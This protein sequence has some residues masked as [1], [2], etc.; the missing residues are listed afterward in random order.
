MMRI[1][2]FAVNRTQQRYFLQLQ[3]ALECPA[4]VRL[5]KR[6]WFPAVLRLFS[7]CNVID[8]E[9]LISR[10]LKELRN[11]GGFFAGGSGQAVMRLYL[12][13]AIPLMAMRYFPSIDD[14]RFDTIAVWNG[15][16]LRQAL[17]VMLSRALGK[18]TLFFENGMLPQTTVCDFHGVN[19][20]N[21]VPREASFYA[22][23][24]NTSG[25]ELPRTLT[26]RPSK[27]G[28]EQRDT[29][30]WLPERFVF[31]PFQVNHD[32]Q[33][34]HHSPWIADMQALFALFEAMAKRFAQRHFILKTHPSD[35]ADY[36]PLEARAGRLDNLAFADSVP[37]Q[38]L[39]ERCNVVCTINSSVGIE[40][41]LYGKPVWVLGEAFY[42][43]EGIT[44]VI[45][46]EAELEAALEN[47][48]TAP[49][50]LLVRSFLE[51]LSG[52]YLIPGSWRAPDEEHMQAL[53]RRLGCGEDVK[54]HVLFMVSTPLHLYNA[55]VAALMHPEWEAHLFFIDQPEE[56]KHP[57]IEALRAW[58]ATPFHSVELFK[59]RVRG[60]WKKWRTRRQA[61][62][63]LRLKVASIAPRRIFVGN[64]RRIEFAYALHIARQIDPGAVGGYLDDGAYTYVY[65]KSR[66]H[67]DTFVDIGLKKLIYGRWY[68]RPS[69]VGG[70]AAV[71]EAY[72]ALPGFVNRALAHKRLHQLETVLLLSD[73]VKPFI[74]HL[75]APYSLDRKAL[76]ALDLVFILPHESLIA[77]F[78][79]FRQTV[80]DSIRS[81]VI[82][83]L[84]VGVKY[85]PRQDDPDPLGLGTMQGIMTL[86]NTLAF[87]ALL[88]L[89]GHAV[90]IG[91]VSSAL[92]TARWLRP[93]LRVLSLRNRADTRQEAMG[94]LFDHVGVSLV[95]P[96]DF[97]STL[98]QELSR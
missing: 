40:A 31:V 60:A 36:S 6:L 94:A 72:V 44:H 26:V 96:T 98:A 16:H 33:I 79:Q 24:V 29:G 49:D 61:F 32:T 93:D 21:S 34:T 14:V 77:R 86:P 20:D 67:Q 4:D 69:V 48:P 42:A 89:L 82:Q 65:Q 74:D 12:R 18:R 92:L 28:T 46:S 35:P 10:K 91:D 3:T 75:V 51:Y 19:A 95:D 45:R 64:D 57:Y 71:E 66:W 56:Q 58:E 17:I 80:L 23:Y 41:L 53:N 70:S 81:A 63:T 11:T 83:G 52:E 25:R 47:P 37:T 5:C 78:A 7:L 87:E 54:E 9:L 55:I 84:H 76:K 90:I 88:P 59:T 1:R 8:S 39:I 62:T 15:K 30:T 13:L 27:K 38:T 73:R 85:H 50:A 68:F 2:F 22:G 97:Q 43:I